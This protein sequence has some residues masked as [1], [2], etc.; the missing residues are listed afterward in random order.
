MSA[1]LRLSWLDRALLAIAPGYGLRRVHA[2]ARAQ[3]MARGYDAISHGRRTAGWQRTAGDANATN[4]PALATLRELSRDLRRNNGWARRAIEV[5]ANNTVGWGIKAKAVGAREDINER[6]LELWDSWSTDPRADY[7]GRLPFEGGIQGLVMETVVES[8]EALI[9]RSVARSKDGLAIPTRIRVLEPDHLDTYK[10]GVTGPSG[11]PIIQG[12]ELDG[13][14][15]RVAYWLHPEHPGA[16]GTFAAR[17]RMMRSS[18][19]RVLAENVIHVYEVLR[20]GQMRGIPR[21]AAAMARLHDFDDYSDAVLMQQKIAACFGAFVQDLDGMGEGVGQP[22]TGTGGDGKDEPLDML[23]PGHIAYLPPG[24]T[25]SFATPPSTADHGSFSNT[26]EHAIAAAIG[27]PHE[28][29]TGDYRQVTFSS[30]RM[31]RIA[32]WHNVHRWRWRMLIPQLCDGVWRWVMEDAAAIEGW[33]EIPRAEWSPPPM[34]MLEPDKEGRANRD[35]IR[36]GTRTV[37]D[38][39]R[40]QGEDPDA[41][42]QEIARWNARMDELGIVLDCDPRKV[43][44]AGLTQ[45]R[46]GGGSE[47]GA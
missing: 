38:I 18:S 9:L 33:R 37:A 8:G 20:P 35:L 32:H 17:S 14:G 30:A 25:V 42:F 13:E 41:H 16:S 40:E 2:R 34:P 47:G 12:I 22:G 11:G 28:E 43:S 1:S 36:S 29:M 4:M 6:A 15:R 45:E 19:V 24:K 44:A 23:E 5:I 21:L 7:D 26:M 27:I 10:D 46:P 3:L 31:S 39:I